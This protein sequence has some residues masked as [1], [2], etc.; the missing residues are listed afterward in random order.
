MR[1]KCLKRHKEKSLALSLLMM[2]AI[3]FFLRRHAIG[4]GMARTESGKNGHVHW[5]SSFTSPGIRGNVLNVAHGHGAALP[6]REDLAHAL[7]NEAVPGRYFLAA[8]AQNEIQ[9]HQSALQ[10]RPVVLFKRRYLTWKTDVI[11]ANCL[12]ELIDPQAA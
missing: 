6:R 1:G 9:L 7:M 12:A 3:S 4:R 8:P 11:S 10:V 2:R 5:Q